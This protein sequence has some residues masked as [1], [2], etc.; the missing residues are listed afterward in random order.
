MF[1]RAEQRQPNGGN[2]IF[3]CG[4][5]SRSLSWVGLHQQ[6]FHGMYMPRTFCHFWIFSKGMSVKDCVSEQTPPHWYCI[7]P[8]PSCSSSVGLSPLWHDGI[9]RCLSLSS[10]TERQQNPRCKRETVWGL[11]TFCSVHCQCCWII[12]CHSHTFV[13]QQRVCSMTSHGQKLCFF[14]LPCCL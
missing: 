6:C 5:E 4:W 14:T 13:M 8:L 10:S 3:G 2:K 9:P 1:T 11:G 7:A 12:A